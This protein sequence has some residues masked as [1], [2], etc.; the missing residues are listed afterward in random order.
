MP[1][2]IVY[3]YKLPCQS[4]DTALA[5]HNM[6]ACCLLNHPGAESR[7]RY[8]STKLPVT[9][10]ERRQQ[11]QMREALLLDMQS[12]TPLFAT[13]TL[14]SSHCWPILWIQV[15]VLAN[16]FFSNM[17]CNCWILLLG[18]ISDFMPSIHCWRQRVW[19][20]WR[21]STLHTTLDRA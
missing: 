17:C 6:N 11:I 10:W 1:F 16:C 7:M 21:W 8:S 19:L 18:K 14:K 9:C 3:L 5:S 2:I 12:W 4:F 13:R 20:T 15:T